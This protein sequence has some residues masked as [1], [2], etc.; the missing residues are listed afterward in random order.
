MVGILS[1]PIMSYFECH[2]STNEPLQELKP[3]QYPRAGEL[4]RIAAASCGLQMN[5]VCGPLKTG[6]GVLANSNINEVLARSMR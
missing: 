5:D 6:T 4:G 3:L 2:L 1:P